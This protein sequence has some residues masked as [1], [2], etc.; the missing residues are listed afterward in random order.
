MDDIL[1]KITE[2]IAREEKHFFE[3]FDSGKITLTRKEKPLEVLSKDEFFLI[4][5]CKKG[6]PSKGV[7]VDD[8]S[9]VELAKAYEKAGA[10][11]VSVLTEKNYFHGAKKHLAMVKEAVSIP[12]LRKDFII[13][14]Y[15]I[16]EA[17]ELG[18]DIVLLIVACL[19]DEKLRE[20]YDLI[21]SYGMTPLVEVHNQ[22]ELNRALE[23]DPVLLGINNRD[24]KTFKTDIEISFRLKKLIPNKVKVISESGIKNNEVIERLKTSG[25]FGALIGESILISSDVRVKINELMG[26]R[27]I[28]ICGI[29]NQQDFDALANLGVDYLGFIFYEK[30]P[31]YVSSSRVAGFNNNKATKVG[32]FVNET[33]DRIREV[34]E[35]AKLD[36]VQ[37][38]GDEAP[39][40]CKELGL[41]FWKAIRVKDE[42]SLATIDSFPKGTKFLLDG[43]AKDSYGGTGNSIQVELITKALEKTKNIVVAG[44]IGL[45]NIKELLK[46]PFIEI[47][48][49]SSV[50]LSPGNK[51]IVKCREIIA[52]A[53]GKK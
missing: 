43:F 26:R 5:E 21:V 49:N 25:F 22:E 38:H 13:H 37:L 23:L 1:S 15:Q 51:D 36:I 29:T 4:A 11:A 8:Y 33:A 16:Y 39:E 46:I 30:S 42:S 32:V 28:K 48:V 41:P 2:Q 12:V 31:R 35:E 44:G 6:S 20:L 19:G 52:I 53:K 9:P 14:P 10:S 50:E 7:L 17:Y 45:E 47:D 40:F 24:L 3:A 18:A 27:G 34:Y